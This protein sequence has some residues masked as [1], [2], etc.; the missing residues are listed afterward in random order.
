[1]AFRDLLLL[2]SL[3]VSA[4]FHTGGCATL[5]R[6]AVVTL[7]DRV[8]SPPLCAKEGDLEPPDDELTMVGSKAYY[9]GFLSTPLEETRGDGTDQAIKL[10]GGA[11]GVMGVLLLGFLASNGLL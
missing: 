1:M 4:A 8:R 9:E 11:V 5:H 7:P 10:A 6:R 3:A 2:L